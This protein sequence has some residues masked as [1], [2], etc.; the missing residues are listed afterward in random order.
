[1][2]GFR[3]VHLRMA[4]QAYQEEQSPFSRGSGGYAPDMLIRVQELSAQA[5][6]RLKP[7]LKS[8]LPEQ[9]PQFVEG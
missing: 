4:Q 1:M 3:A 2:N 6:G 7:F 9:K 8:D 5:Q